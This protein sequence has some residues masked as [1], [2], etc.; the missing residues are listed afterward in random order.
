MEGTHRAVRTRS[1]FNSTRTM[2]IRCGLFLGLIAVLAVPL[3]SQ[4]TRR[5]ISPA[6]AFD[7]FLRAAG[8]VDRPVATLTGIWPLAIDARAT[9][10]EVR[11]SAAQRIDLRFGTD[12]IRRDD[13]V[14]V[15]T[16]RWTERVRDTLVLLDRVNAIVRVLQQAS[17]PPDQCSD[18]LGSPAHLFAIQN[19]IVRWRRGVSGQPTQ[20]SWDVAP[21]PVYEITVDVGAPMD[22]GATPLACNAKMP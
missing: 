6:G 16:A 1:L 21:G 10:T 12:A 4:I 3:Q 15:R 9:D 18:L 2:T 22:A 13:S 11:V 20:L 14:R 19:T 7:S 17:G 5:A 8:T